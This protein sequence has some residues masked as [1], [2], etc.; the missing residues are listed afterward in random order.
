MMKK[1]A[2]LA[3]T[4]AMIFA[5]A[6]MADNSTLTMGY[7]ESVS[8]EGIYDRGQGINVKF[9]HDLAD[10]PYGF[11]AS[12]TFT[13]ADEAKQLS[14]LDAEMES[15][16]H[17]LMVGP[18]VRVLPDL[19]FYGLVGGASINASTGGALG[20]ADVNELGWNYGVGMKFN[21]MPNIAIDLH[22]EESHFDMPMMNNDMKSLSFGAGFVF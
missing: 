13:M 6:A 3:L 10:K 7:V 9:H 4:G 15:K 17:S 5:T 20:S 11:V 8:D 12:A 19:A 1:I 2:L 22:Y 14:A 21:P 18:S 16:Y